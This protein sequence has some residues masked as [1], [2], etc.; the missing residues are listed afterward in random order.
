[1]APEVERYR[2][3]W[4]WV[5]PRNIRQ[6]FYLGVHRVE[7]GLMLDSA[8]TTR[9]ICTSSFFDIRM[10]MDA[11]QSLFSFSL[12]SLVA[13]NVSSA[14]RN[15]REPRMDR[16]WRSLYL[17]L[18]VLKSKESGRGPPDGDGWVGEPFDGFGM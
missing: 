12:S 16:E 8:G 3:E 17:V 15:R 10:G 13:P 1:M 6:G 14:M 11:R 5:G 9:N 4:I 7:A 2:P 18:Y